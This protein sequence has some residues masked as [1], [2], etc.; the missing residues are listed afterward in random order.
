LVGRSLQF[1]VA[2][3]GYLLDSRA[4]ILS[5]INLILL[6]ISLKRDSDGNV[7]TFSRVLTM[8]A[9]M[10]I[11]KLLAVAWILSSNSGR[12]RINVVFNSSISYHLLSLIML[13]LYHIDIICQVIL[14][15]FSQKNLNF[16]K[17]YFTCFFTC[18]KKKAGTIKKPCR[19]SH[20]THSQKDYYYYNRV[21][22]IYK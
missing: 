18:L 1:G 19:L 15:Q 9:F 5:S 2:A 4:S 14:H 8:K 6:S 21:R 13:L 11:P 10:L 7:S 17:K 16:S 22:I 20:L 3:P 12:R